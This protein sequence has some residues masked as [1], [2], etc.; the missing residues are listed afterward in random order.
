MLSIIRRFSYIALVAV[1]GVER[2]PVEITCRD[3][4]ISTLAFLI[5]SANSTMITTNARSTAIEMIMIFET[6][7]FS[8]FETLSMLSPTKVIPTTFPSCVRGR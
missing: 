4:A 1:T 7:S 2:S 3:S 5:L 8:T 6:V